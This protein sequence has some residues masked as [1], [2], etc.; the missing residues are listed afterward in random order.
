[1]ISLEGVTYTYE[2]ESEP[3]LRDLSLTVHSGEFVLILGPSGSARA[4]CSIC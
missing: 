4:R 3:I 1:M 2:G